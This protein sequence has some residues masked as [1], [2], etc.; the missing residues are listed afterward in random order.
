MVG[1][2]ASCRRRRA[3]CCTCVGAQVP[4]QT[5]R[6]I[7]GREMVGGI[8][9]GAL[10][11]FL[12][13]TGATV[14]LA[15]NSARPSEPAGVAKGVPLPS[16]EL[17]EHQSKPDCET[18]SSSRLLGAVQETTQLIYERECYKNA[19][20]VARTKLQL[21]QEAI[22]STIKA[23]NDAA[24]SR[25]LQPPEGGEQGAPAPAKDAAIAPTAGASAASRSS[26]ATGTAG[27]RRDAKSNPSGDQGV[28][29]PD[30][31]RKPTPSARLSVNP[32]SR[33]GDV[34]TSV[35]AVA[36]QTSSPAGHGHWAWRLID[37]RKCWYEGAVGMDKSLLHW[38]P[39]KE[40][41][42]P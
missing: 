13:V 3:H 22:G 9:L 32:S 1:I 26:E 11:I 38:L 36:C 8:L 25:T 28:E 29:L 30:Q 18:P 15:Q 23:L 17:L 24:A 14:T 31:H 34:P 35:K 10:S 21:L 16:P 37:G 20:I 12:L 6:L 42:A 27:D 4:G 40:V 39:F 19:E 33:A 2:V 5:C 41:R 7:V